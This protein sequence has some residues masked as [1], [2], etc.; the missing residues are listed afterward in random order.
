MLK[1]Y[2]KWYTIV[3]RLDIFIIEYL[4]LEIRETFCLLWLLS[5]FKN[6]Q[7]EEK[8]DQIDLNSV[9]TSLFA[10]D[11]LYLSLFG[12]WKEKQLGG[13]VFG[14]GLWRDHPVSRF[15]RIFMFILK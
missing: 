9:S 3:K 6:Q 4:S 10:Q 12:L 5:R 1:L 2:T 14:S 11:T 13:M 15:L 7:K 8:K